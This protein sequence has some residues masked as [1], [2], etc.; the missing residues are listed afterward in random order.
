L[1]SATS[2]PTASTLCES[3]GTAPPIAVLFVAAGLWVL[4]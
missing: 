4:G 1:A 2:L 3:T